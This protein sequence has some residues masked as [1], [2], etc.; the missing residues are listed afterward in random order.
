MQAQQ[1]STKATFRTLASVRWLLVVAL[2]VAVV[3]H[4]VMAV[5]ELGV[6]DQAVSF[7]LINMA[8]DLAPALVYAA[9][10]VFVL[11]GRGT[12]LAW[13]ILFA[14]GLALCVVSAFYLVTAGFGEL[15]LPPVCLVALSLLQLWSLPSSRITGVR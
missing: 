4:A 15:M 6:A 9:A 8:I 3:L 13:S 5:R 10:V 1:E 12:R 14:C 7:Y 11:V 2:A